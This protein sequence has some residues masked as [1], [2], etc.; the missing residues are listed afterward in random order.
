MRMDANV[1]LWLHL[2]S[3]SSFTSCPL[4]F[5][6]SSASGNLPFQKSITGGGPQQVARELV[7][8][9]TNFLCSTLSF[10]LS[11]DVPVQ[12]RD[13]VHIIDLVSVKLASA[14]STGHCWSSVNGDQRATKGDQRATIVT[15]LDG[16]GDGLGE[17]REVHMLPV[18]H[19]HRLIVHRLSVH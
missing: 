13:T 8:P 9:R 2:V 17:D 5:A 7:I 12:R 6:S 18:S 4:V 19:R 3:P 15:T 1:P 14:T 11:S 16:V 10:L